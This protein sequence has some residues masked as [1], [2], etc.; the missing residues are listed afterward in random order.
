MLVE[1]IS[2]FLSH[3][4]GDDFEALAAD[5]FRFQY[6]K[7]PAYRRLCD[8][9]GVVPGGLASWQEIPAV[10]AL[11]FKSLPL[12]AA[13]ARELFRSSG[14]SSD[15][16]SEHHHPYPDL[17]RHVI[18]ASFPTACLGHTGRLP[19]L[20]LIPTREQAPDSSLAFMVE[21]ILQS[22]GEPS[23]RTI[24]GPRGVE[25]TAARSWLG[26]RQRE[27]RPVLIL[28][29]AFAL[30]ALLDGL[31]RLG[32]RFRLPPG[33]LL[34][35]TGGFKGRRQ[36]VS[37]GDLLERL[38][39]RLA[40]PPQRIVRE[41]GMTELTSQFYTG[42]LDG[43]DADLF[44]PPPWTRVR[45]LS[46][47]TLAEQPPGEPGLIAIFDLANL[48]SAIHL[49]TEDLGVTEGDGFRLR[50]RAAGAELRGC[51]LTVEELQP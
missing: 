12:A 39:D 23:S 4:G 34:F 13:P 14:T 46:P 32:L 8:G 42:S 22:W 29:T 47:E 7:I 31:D 10:P 37:R 20:S 35:E 49:L 33:S 36:E 27:G 21:H 19:M 16:R 48:G 25:A 41:Y 24:F 18:D 43:G 38:H 45:I 15:S 40:L 17:Y 1:R 50:G 51:S 30:V 26:A 28:A 44:L 6:E 11:A 2:A 9:R 3:S 5:A